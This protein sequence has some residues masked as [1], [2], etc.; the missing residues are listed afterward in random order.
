MDQIY[1]YFTF[2]GEGLDEQEIE[3]KTKRLARQWSDVSTQA[4][5]E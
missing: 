5:G 2:G 4:R 1:D 3:N